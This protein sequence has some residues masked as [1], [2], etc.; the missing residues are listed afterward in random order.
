[1]SRMARRTMARVKREYYGGSLLLQDLFPPF[2]ELRA[3]SCGCSPIDDGPIRTFLIEPVE[4][5]LPPEE[6]QRCTEH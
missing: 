2:H 5:V 6:L 4:K 3:T 1:M